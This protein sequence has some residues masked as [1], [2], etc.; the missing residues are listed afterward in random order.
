MLEAVG[1]PVK[2]GTAWLDA[3]GTTSIRPIIDP[4]FLTE[5]FVGKRGRGQRA[6]RPG[7]A[8]GATCVVLSLGPPT[9]RLECDPS[10]N[11][12]TKK[13][14]LAARTKRRIR[15][16]NGS[17]IRRKSR[18]PAQASRLA[19]ALGLPLAQPLPGHALTG[20]STAPSSRGLG[21]CVV[22]DLISK[23]RPPLRMPQAWTCRCSARSL[24]SSIIECENDYRILSR[25]Q[26]QFESSARPLLDHDAP[27]AHVDD[28]ESRG[29]A[30]MGRHGRVPGTREPLSS[31]RAK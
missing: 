8:F 9:I 20:P 1:P 25:V 22:I 4:A 21:R 7:P 12:G 26:L 18:E 30:S 10:L 2:A 24:P 31:K 19:V 16:F 13:A 15:R 11:E 29:H 14:S 28:L 17:R 27:P 5:L 3:D 23:L 6:W